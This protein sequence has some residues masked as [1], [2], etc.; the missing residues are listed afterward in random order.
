M[1]VVVMISTVLE[2]QSELT[3]RGFKDVRVMRMHLRSISILYDVHCE[4]TCLEHVLLLLTLERVLVLA[5]P[6][7]VSVML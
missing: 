7:Y 4:P 6:E 2:V 5:N 3:V 1:T